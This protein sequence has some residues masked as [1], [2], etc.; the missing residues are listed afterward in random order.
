MVIANLKLVE[1]FRAEFVID[2]PCKNRRMILERLYM[3]V[4]PC[5][6]RLV[7]DDF[8]RTCRAT[9]Q[10]I[11]DRVDHLLAGGVES[12]Q[13]LA[14]HVA[15][16]H[17]GIERTVY[18]ILKHLIRIPGYIYRHRIE[19]L[20]VHEKPVVPVDANLP[21]GHLLHTVERKLPAFN[22]LAVHIRELQG[23]LRSAGRKSG[24]VNLRPCNSTG[25]LRGN[26][27][28]FRRS[29]GIPFRQFCQPAATGIRNLKHRLVSLGRKFLRR[30]EQRRRKN[31]FPIDGRIAVDVGNERTENGARLGY[32]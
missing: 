26:N 5:V 31:C 9:E 12:V 8:F 16:A 15:V 4:D 1:P 22:H 32:A 14:R 6:L 28:S 2:V 29:G 17:H 3:I 18:D 19:R 27:D 11:L 30:G 10:D 7:I 21:V 25:D 20:A 13:L 24:D 23:Y